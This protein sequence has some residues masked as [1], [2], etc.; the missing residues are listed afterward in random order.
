MN[1]R[2]LSATML[3]GALM[4]YP[5]HCQNL[6]TLRYGQNAAGTG[7]LSSLPL[8]VALRKDYFRR[9]GI[10]LVV[11]PIPGGTDRIVAALDKGEIDAGK[12]ATPYTIQAV[13]KGSDA[14]A[15]MSQTANPV[16]SL[17][18]RRE[19]RSFNDIKGKTLGLSTPG[20]TITLS[21]VRLLTA[22]G[23]KITDYTAKPVVGTPARF[24]CLKSGE[25]AAVPMGQP[26]DLGAIAQGFPRL[27]FTNEAVAD[28]IFNVDMAR[29][30]W[31]A[32]NK[33]TM[34]RFVRAM[35]ATYAYM[36]NPNNR[37][38]IVG[39]VRDTGKLSDAVAQQ[40]FAP[41]LEIGK[42]VLPRKGE[43]DSGAF[44]RVLALMGEVG[45]IPKPVPPAERFIDLQYLKAAGIE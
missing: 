44:N 18:V 22:N 39:I 24:D 36:N 32:Q 9:E 3:I 33:D 10:D 37:G 20:D 14:V 15:F 16:Y 43:I 11:V 8:N 45:A 23:L 29:R 4:V 42:N 7:G 21:T 38:E 25:C 27:A 13:L 26:E 5:A 1:C 30:A 19:I 41:Y 12:N 6:V 35:S 31:A 28:L 17:I 2:I 34:V 40:I